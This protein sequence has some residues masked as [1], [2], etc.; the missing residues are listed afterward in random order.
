MSPFLSFVSIPPAPKK[1]IH[2]L[3]MLFNYLNYYCMVKK[4]VCAGADEVVHD[5]KD[6]LKDNNSLKTKIELYKK[7]K[8]QCEKK[9]IEYEEQ[10]PKLTDELAHVKRE[11]DAI[12]REIADRTEDIKEMEANMMKMELELA[13]SHEMI[14]T[15]AAYQKY[16]EKIAALR[17]EAE[18]MQTE[19][20][21]VRIRNDNGTKVVKNYSDTIDEINK[22]LKTH[23]IEPYEELM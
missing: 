3:K 15:D 18:Q 4:E 11:Y 7:E 9:H 14:V 2:V 17:A 6:A 10:M 16:T 23:S 8:D 12:Q 1:T 21:E 19:I 22:M 20:E 5:Y 13:E